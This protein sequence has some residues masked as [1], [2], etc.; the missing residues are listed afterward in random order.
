[1]E[2]FTQQNQKIWEILKTEP[3]AEV[4]AFPNSLRI[5]IVLPYDCHVSGLIYPH[6]DI[7]ELY[8]GN[9]EVPEEFQRHG[10]GERLLRIL[11]T[12]AK[13]MGVNQLRGHVISQGGLRSL[14]KVLGKSNM[15]LHESRIPDPERGYLVGKKLD[16][17]FEDI[18]ENDIDYDLLS[19]LD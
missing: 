7:Q 11:I 17:N 6:G 8:V 13:K 12:E 1:M 9:F 5:D 18:K 2:E 15:S 14:I 10:I 19:S 3:I 16:I 4:K